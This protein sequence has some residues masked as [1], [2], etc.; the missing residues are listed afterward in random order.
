MKKYFGKKLMTKTCAAVVAVG[1]LM[2]GC[3][4]KRGGDATTAADTTADVPG[5]SSDV[6]GTTAEYVP[7]DPKSAV[8]ELASIDV[9]DYIDMSQLKDLQIKTS[10][11]IASDA[12]IKYNIAA[13]LASNYGFS[14]ETVDRAVEPGDLVVIDYKGTINGILFNGGTAEDAEL[15]IGSGKFIP[16]FEDGIIGKKAGVEF[17]LPVTFPENYQEPNYAGK[18]AVF[19]VTVKKVQKM[20]DDTDEQIKEKSKD[21]Y[22]TYKEFYD[23]TSA[24]IKQNYHDSIILG[25]IMSVIEEKK[26]HE[27]LIN[28]YVQQ[29]L[30]NVDRICMNY[31][32]DRVTYLNGAGIT[33]D[34]FESMLK[35]N[36]Q[37]Y[38]KQKLTILGICRQ[39]GLDIKEGELDAFKQK[40]VDQYDELTSVDQLADLMAEDELEYQ[41]YYDKFLE[42]LKNYK[43]VDKADEVETTTEAVKATEVETTTEAVKATEVETTTEA[44][45][46]ETEK[47]VGGVDPEMKA[48]LDSYEAFVDEYVDFMKKN[49]AD[50]ANALEMKMKYNDFSQKAEQYNSEDMSEEDSKYYVEVMSRCSQK[51]MQAAL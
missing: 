11:V 47:S 38:S 27:G 2:T 33:V 4:P 51:M 5:T 28:E 6:E 16:G 39:E 36:G 50:P 44:A 43:T 12:F 19:K 26:Q 21:K 10:D 20:Q 34:E 24:E 31:G 13:A 41:L 23:A 30:Y 46:K 40:L 7:A 25:R 49:S 32:I 35:E 48:F 22:A 3:A 14:W 8:I 1:L 18:D 9:N 17:D 37:A 29:Q 15:G 45:N 42:Y